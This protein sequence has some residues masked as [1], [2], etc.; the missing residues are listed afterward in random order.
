MMGLRLRDGVK[1]EHLSA[2]GG[3]DWLGFI[4]ESHLQTAQ[5]E[6]WII[7]DDEF[8]R[9]SRE[10]ML[11]LNALVPYILKAQVPEVQAG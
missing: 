3:Q 9:L 6:G 4:D 5:D 8:M 10:G 1:L 11:R 2:Q 7:T